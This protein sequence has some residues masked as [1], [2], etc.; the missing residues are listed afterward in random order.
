MPAYH[1]SAVEDLA[2]RELA[3][4]KVDYFSHAWS[5]GET[6]ATQRLI[7]GRKDLLDT[8]GYSKETQ[9]RC[10]NLLW[11]LQ[12]QLAYP[13]LPRHLFPPSSSPSTLRVLP[14][15]HERWRN[16]FEKYN[17]PLV[18][19]FHMGMNEEEGRS[20]SSSPISYLPTPC[21]SSSALHI[22]F[23]L[24]VT[25]SF[26]PSSSSSSSQWSIEED[27]SLVGTALIPDS[28]STASSSTTTSLPPSPTSISPSP[29]PSSSYPRGL[30]RHTRFLSRKPALKKSTSS[31]CLS[32]R[33]TC[34]DR[35][36]LSHL[37]LGGQI[38]A[39]QFAQWSEEDP[40]ASYLPLTPRSPHG[41]SS[42]LAIE[43]PDCIS[44]LLRLTFCPTV[45]QRV[46]VDEGEEE[47]VKRDTG[48]WGMKMDRPCRL[49]FGED[50]DE[51]EEE[52]EE[53]EDRPFYLYERTE[54][55][56]SSG[57]MM[58]LSDYFGISWHGSDDDEEE[59]DEGMDLSQLED[60]EGE[61]EREEWCA[62]YGTDHPS[63]HGH[64]E[65]PKAGWVGWEVK[66][67]EIRQPLPPPPIRLIHDAP[68]AKRA[69]R[70][71]KR[72]FASTHHHYHSPPPPLVSP[73]CEDNDCDD[74]SD[75]DTDGVEDGSHSPSFS[76]SPSS[77]YHRPRRRALSTTATEWISP[78]PW[79]TWVFYLLV[80]AY[81][82]VLWSMSLRFTS[83]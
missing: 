17:A 77:T 58:G 66:A 39:R 82:L 70:R 33:E 29:S 45:E 4:C 55:I 10:E 5:L 12:Y 57:R 6:H 83:A 41:P 65:A 34:R 14:R 54:S 78:I 67:R 72:Q 81:D 1:P 26:P 31:L 30:T 44:P 42:S 21:V 9:A 35:L 22:H 2:H 79:I 46:I 56:T 49:K 25:Q 13:I 62:E 18:G 80:G 68:K 69:R 64:V 52:E 48:G 74:F 8:S 71:Q 23:P 20:G 76:S 60:E 11:R 7:W 75:W 28:V 50:D 16:Q 27:I 40:W 38:S 51:E 47:E 61:E 63:P 15:P 3:K 59:E 19:P 36:K 43:E 37:D 32:L 24:H 73:P 53:E